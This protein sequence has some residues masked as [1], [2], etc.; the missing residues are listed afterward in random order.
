MAD[1]YTMGATS[2]LPT[3][4]TDLATTFTADNY[5]AVSAVD[6]NF[7]SLSENGS[8]CITLF[9]NSNT[10]STAVFSV[11]WVGSAGCNASQEP[12]MMEI[13]DVAGGSWSNLINNT[14]ATA[15][16]TVTLSTQI[17]DNLSKYYDANS[18]IICRVYQ[19]LPAS[20]QLQQ[21]ENMPGKNI[22]QFIGFS[23]GIVSFCAI[24]IPNH[25][26]FVK[27]IVLVSGASTATAT[28]T[29]NHTVQLGL[30]SRTGG[31][32][33]LLNSAS[34]NFTKDSLASTAWL[35][36]VTSATSNIFPGIYY[37]GLNI[38]TGGA[39]SLFG[40][41]GNSSV[42]PTNVQ[43][44]VLSG[45]ATVTTNALPASIGTDVLDITGADAIRQP[46]VI[47]SS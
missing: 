45:H 32:L 33:T 22:T 2:V 43:P 26:S 25:L 16:Q 9:K 46:Y 18:S 34:G 4:T 28:R 40:I 14:T 1:L 19:S 17:I 15:S 31:T 20:F 39:T 13:Y 5:T 37:I 11:S 21:F 35:S 12:L 42:S 36:M 44:V 23:N 29:C 30:Y 8:Y 24:T 41:A 27:P 38:L 6:G 10:N 7:V 47:I 3:V